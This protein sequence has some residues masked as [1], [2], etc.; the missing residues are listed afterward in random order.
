MQCRGQIRK[1]QRDVAEIV[2]STTLEGLG[3]DERR[4]LL[5]LYFP[6]LTAVCHYVQSR[7]KRTAK[8]PSVGSNPTRASKIL[9][10]LVRCR[11]LTLLAIARFHAKFVVS[12]TG[13]AYDA[14]IRRPEG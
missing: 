5:V 12:R 14:R 13:E 2:A 1:H 6:M 3:T 10:R 8:P 11:S 9:N 4:R 7:V